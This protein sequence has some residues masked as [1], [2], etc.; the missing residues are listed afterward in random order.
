[1][2]RFNADS[3]KE[4]NISSGSGTRVSDEKSSAVPKVELHIKSVDKNDQ[5]KKESMAK[6]DADA[7]SV[8]NIGK[9]F[10]GSINRNANTPNSVTT[11]NYRNSTAFFENLNNTTNH[12][13]RSSGKTANQ[14]QDQSPV[15]NGIVLIIDKNNSTLNNNDNESNGVTSNKFNP[16]LLNNNNFTKN[17]I[18]STIS[19]KLIST[20]TNNR[21]NTISDDD[22]TIN[23]NTKLNGNSDSNNAMQD[24]EYKGILERKAEWEKRAS[25]AFK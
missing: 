12:L 3:D 25:Q 15:N 5:L 8:K 7:A 20:T 9:L 13:F 18:A 16:I 6:I 23:I 19:N 17:A 11:N 4:N 10:N 1:M 22:D 2:S 24:H 21:N 14:N